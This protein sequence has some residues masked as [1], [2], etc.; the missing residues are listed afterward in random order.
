M[1]TRAHSLRKKM[2]LAC[3]A[4]EAA[5]AEGRDAGGDGARQRRSRAADALTWLAVVV[6][7]R[8]DEAGALKLVEQAVRLA[9]ENFDAQFA[10]GRARFGAGDDAGAVAAFRAAV[11]LRPA[12]ARARF[13]L[14]T[15]LERA[16]DTDGA[17]DAYRELAASQPRV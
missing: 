8:G 6:A 12:D 13:F 10:L 14:A 16:G 2:R 11:A 1:S 3:G 9:P 4:V 15:A 17:L 7:V 5:R